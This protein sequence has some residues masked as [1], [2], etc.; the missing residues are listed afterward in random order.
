MSG[1][2]NRRVFELQPREFRVLVRDAVFWGIVMA[3]LF[4]GLVAS[5]LSVFLV[6]MR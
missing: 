5:L 6:A 4:I 3:S 2:D 1:D